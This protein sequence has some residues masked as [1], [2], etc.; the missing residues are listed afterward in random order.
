MNIIN[1]LKPIN[2]SS[3]RTLFEIRCCLVTFFSFYFYFL[4]RMIELFNSFTPKTAMSLFNTTELTLPMNVFCLLATL[5]MFSFMAYLLY[6]GLIQIRDFYR[7]FDLLNSP[8]IQ[9]LIS[10]MEQESN[11]SIARYVN[12][13]KKQSREISFYEY[14]RITVEIKEF[15]NKKGLNANQIMRKNM[16]ERLY[17]SADKRA[18]Y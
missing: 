5:F 16:L 12:G 7:T 11:G 2:H 8:Q 18:L 3:P 1:L 9:N 6:F 13:L 17:Q 10:Y 14:E 4:S 15:K